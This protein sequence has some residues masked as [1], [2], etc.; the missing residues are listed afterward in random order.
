MAEELQ[1][2]EVELL[3]RSATP[4]P[5]KKKKEATR[6]QR[7]CRSFRTRIYASRGGVHYMFCLECGYHFKAVVLSEREEA[8]KA[9]RRQ[10]LKDRTE[11]VSYSEAVRQQA[12]SM[13]LQAREHYD[14]ATVAASKARQ[15]LAAED[16]P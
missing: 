16:R 2:G 5:E 4:C 11:D 15:A 7:K 8:E 14:R 1:N 12:E 6:A 10:R 9:R 3:R 13:Y